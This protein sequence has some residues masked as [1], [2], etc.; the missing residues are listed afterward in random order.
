MPDNTIPY[1]VIALVNEAT[2]KLTRD[3][4]ANVPGSAI[5]IQGYDGLVGFTGITADGIPFT[6]K[7]SR[8][9]DGTDLKDEL[10]VTRVDGSLEIFAMMGFRN[11]LRAAGSSD[12]DPNEGDL[13]HMLVSALSGPEGRSDRR[14]TV[15]DLGDD[16]AGFP[17]STTSARLD[18]C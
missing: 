9:E 11:A 10:T 3:Y 17:T 16:E 5:Q 8:T 4:T 18:L 2:T 7:I 14:F 6:Y 1:E 13:A 12:A 15:I